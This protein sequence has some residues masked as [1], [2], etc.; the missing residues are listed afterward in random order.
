MII[1]SKPCGEGGKTL[2]PVS[3]SKYGSFWTRMALVTSGVLLSGCVKL[4]GVSRPATTQSAP[5]GA[6]SDGIWAAQE[7]RGEA[8]EFVMY[9]HEFGLRSERLTLD[10]EDHVKQIAS[11]ILNGSESPVVVERSMNNKR[12]GRFHY[13]VHPDPELDNQRRNIVVSALLELGV[14]DAE[15]LVVVA[16]AFATPAFGQEAAAAFARTIG[17]NNNSSSS[18]GGGFGGFSGGGIGGGG[19]GGGFIGTDVGGDTSDVSSDP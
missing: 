6:I 3:K 18:F 10:G 12:L 1:E 2:V 4:N 14:A 17:G 19:R 9:A 13:P 5:L 11:R 7:H 16:P 15:E 8:S